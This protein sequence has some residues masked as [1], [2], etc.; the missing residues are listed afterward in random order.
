MKARRWT[1]EHHL[2]GVAAADRS[3]VVVAKADAEAAAATTSPRT[4]ID[5]LRLVSPS[6][7]ASSV[8]N[9]ASS[10]D[11]AAS[12]QVASRHT[13]YRLCSIAY[14]IVGSRMTAG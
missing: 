1:P 14:R 12:H 2:P 11:R 5:P 3:D 9:A 7:D 13:L 4:R 8:D 10:P 6:I